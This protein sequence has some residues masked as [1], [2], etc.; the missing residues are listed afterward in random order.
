MRR[1]FARHP[2]TIP[3]HVMAPDGQRLEGW[4]AWLEATG[5]GVLDLLAE[6]IRRKRAWHQGNAA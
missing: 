4:E 6:S 3:D 5:Y 2:V 1:R